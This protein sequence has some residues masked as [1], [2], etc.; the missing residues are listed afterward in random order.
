MI[1]NQFDVIGCTIVL[2]E[3]KP[4]LLIY[5]NTPPSCQIAFQL[6][7]V[8]RRRNPHIINV[9]HIGQGNQFAIGG[10]NISGGKRRGDSALKMAFVSV[11][12]NDRIMF[13]PS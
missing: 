11:H 2:A 13:N 5:P 8:I 4:I 12:P 10:P 6:F 7:Q 9:D 1:I 3:H